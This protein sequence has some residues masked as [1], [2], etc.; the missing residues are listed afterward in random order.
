MSTMPAT[1]QR[2]AHRRRESGFS[3]IEVMIAAFI[4]FVIVGIAVNMVRSGNEM[5][6]I[7]TM[8]TDA[9]L[10]A[11]EYAR[12]IT[13]RIRNG[14]IDQVYDGTGG[15]GTGTYGTALATGTYSNDAFEIRMFGTMVQSVNTAIS[16][17]VTWSATSGSTVR[18]G[19]L[20]SAGETAGNNTDDDGDGLIDERDLWF[21]SW[22]GDKLGTGTGGHQSVKIGTMVKS[23]KVT[24]QD[25]TLT[26]EV[27]VF[28][29]D[30]VLQEAREVTS[31]SSVL[32]RN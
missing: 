21:E 14:M 19:L 25:N 28:R 24:R 17:G 7:Q 31:T 2:D 26:V 30:R 23:L 16:G 22:T 29:Y 27:V 9:N 11:E 6:T 3:L 32:L 13:R 4:L 8:R 15:M 5:L 10:K 20:A 18:F 12:F 1:T